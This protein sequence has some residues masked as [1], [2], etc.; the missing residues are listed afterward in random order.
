[1]KYLVVLV[2]VLGFACGQEEENSDLNSIDGTDFSDLAEESRQATL[3]PALII[4]NIVSAI[5]NLN[6]TDPN[7]IVQDILDALKITG[8]AGATIGGLGGLGAIKTIFDV[9]V[10]SILGLI[11]VPVGIANMILSLVG[12]VILIIFLIDGGDFGSLLGVRRSLSTSWFDF[13]IMDSPMFNQVNKM[14]FDA[15]EKYA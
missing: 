13:D 1:M 4:G 14:I 2:V 6:L 15:Y 9:I 11:S 3:D 12:L 7:S 8:G 5:G 10:G